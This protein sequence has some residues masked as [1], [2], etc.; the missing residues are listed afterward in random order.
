[1]LESYELNVRD[2]VAVVEEQLSSPEFADCF[3]YLPYHDFNAKNDRIYSD[4]MSGEWSWTQ[5]VS[6][7]DPHS[8][9]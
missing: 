1:M 6:Q 7:R 5:A 2:I 3:H 4:L 9:P 8:A